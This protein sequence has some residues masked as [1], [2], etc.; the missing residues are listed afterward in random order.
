M[1]NAMR[2]RQAELMYAAFLKRA[3]SGSAFHTWLLKQ[4]PKPQDRQPEPQGV[5]HSV[6]A[7]P[8]REGLGSFRAAELPFHKGKWS[9]P[10]RTMST[11]LFVVAI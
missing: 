9:A 6:S 3:P 7:S 5:T 11:L 8:S 10:G 1:V 2:R 4:Q